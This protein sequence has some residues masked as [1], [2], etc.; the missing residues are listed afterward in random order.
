MRLAPILTEEQLKT[1]WSATP[2]NV[3]AAL[4][5]EDEENSS[6]FD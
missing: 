2:K 4:R 1:L 6:A 5:S 3:E